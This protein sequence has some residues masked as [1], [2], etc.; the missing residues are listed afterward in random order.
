MAN[1]KLPHLVRG[2]ATYGFRMAV[3]RHLR[4]ILGRTEL[5]ISLRTSDA[6]IARLRCRSVSALC[7]QLIASVEAM[8]EL[9]PGYRKGSESLFPRRP[10]ARE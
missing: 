5:K 8:I 7:V 6:G 9:Q 3:P 2:R 1:Y 4:R 10:Q